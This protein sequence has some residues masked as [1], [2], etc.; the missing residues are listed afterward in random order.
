M[1]SV[2]IR[3][4]S[5]SGLMSIAAGLPLRVIMTRSSRSATASMIR[6]N[7]FFASVSG[8]VFIRP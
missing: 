5:L 4:C 7:L 3:L 1:S 2:A 6:L 8:S